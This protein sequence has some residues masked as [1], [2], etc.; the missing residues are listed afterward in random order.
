MTENVLLQTLEAIK[1]QN[2]ELLEQV[3]CL[4]LET[5][6]DVPTRNES[7]S[8]INQVSDNRVGSNAGLTDDDSMKSSRHLSNQHLRDEMHLITDFKGKN[9]S[10][11]TFIW[12]IKQV[13]QNFSG[14]EKQRLFRLILT[15]KVLRE[16]RTAIDGI[17]IYEAGDLFA[18]LRNEFD[19]VK[20]YDRMALK[21]TKYYQKDEK[22][23]KYSKRFIRTRH[24]VRRALTNYV[25]I[26]VEHKKIL[27]ANG[28]KIALP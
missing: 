10:V 17:E 13:L 11:E 5:T 26:P 28:D 20:N 14:K 22:V 4:E 1:L 3:N 24:D 8:H 9:I 23:N 18:L 27:F 25:S 2:Q 15:Q 19:T 6:T 12:K 16:A 21:G 7:S